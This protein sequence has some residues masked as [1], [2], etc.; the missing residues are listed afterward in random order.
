MLGNL[1][2]LPLPENHQEENFS[3]ATNRALEG[4]LD[5]NYQLTRKISLTAG[6]RAISERF[7]LTNQAQMAGENPSTLGFL[8]GNYPNL[9]FAESEEKEIKESSLAFTYRG[10]LKY[11]FNEYTNVFVNYSKGRRPKVLQFT[12]TGDAQVL[13]AEKVDNYELGFKTT[14]KQRL[15]FDAGIYYQEYTN[16]QTAAWVA[17][18]DSG[19]FNYI[20]KDAGKATAYGAET[21]V[22][23]AVLKGFD[24]FGNY[25]YI[26]SRFDSLNVNGEDQEY[27]GNMFRL[28]PE[29]SFAVGFTAHAQITPGL[30]LFATP[31]YSWKSHIY[32]ED[33][34][35]PGLEQASY[36]LLNFRGGFELPD[37]GITL[38]VYGTNL[39]EEKYIVSAGNTGSL[40]GA[41]TQIPGAPRMVGAKLTWKFSVNEKPYYRRSRLNR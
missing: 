18:A 29:H 6:V 9:L 34:N 16:F 32:F 40:F 36:G 4:F 33:A 11:D 39:L 22:K 10:G 20:V 8:T 30:F 7:I 2:G 23:M 19:E 13:D 26:H 41:P 28:T 17:E 35:T 12:S 3:D 25:A 1:A 14:I 37:H 24:V 38:A 15:W 31:S 5:F 21:S 27:S